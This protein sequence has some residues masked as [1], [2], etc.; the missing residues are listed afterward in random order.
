M[1][2]P[3]DAVTGCRQLG[4]ALG[5]DKLDVKPLLTFILPLENSIFHPQTAR[6][7]EG[8]DTGMHRRRKP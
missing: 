4:S 7:A 5:L 2:L 1:R 8:V 6:A 3:L